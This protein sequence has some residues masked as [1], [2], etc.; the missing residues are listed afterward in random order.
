M[1]NFYVNTL[2]GGIRSQ[3]KSAVD[4]SRLLFMVPGLTGADTILLLADC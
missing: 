1:K 2:S 3:C 4:N